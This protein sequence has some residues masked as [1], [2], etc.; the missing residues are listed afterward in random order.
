MAEINFTNLL[1]KC[2]QAIRDG[3]S[4]QA[5]SYLKFISTQ[6]TP[7]EII[8]KFSELAYRANQFLLAIKFLNPV[9]HPKNLGVKPASPEEKLIYATS[10][11]HLGAIEEATVR[12]K[13]L[14]ADANPEILLHQAFA[15]FA[16]WKYT[17]AIPVLRRYVKAKQL[18]EYRR[19]VGQLNLA[20][21]FVFSG[22]F[23]KAE[24]LL[25][26]IR[27]EFKEQGHS[28]LLGNSLELSA[29]LCLLQNNFKAAANYISEAEII[30]T[31]VSGRYLFYVK[32]TQVFIQLL[33]NKADVNSLAKL[34]VLRNEARD[35]KQ[36]ETLRDCDLFEA[37]ATHNK[38]LIVKLLWGTPHEKYKQRVLSLTGDTIEKLPEFYWTISGNG[39]PSQEKLDFSQLLLDRPKLKLLL[40]ALTQDFYKPLRIGDLFSRIYSEEKF[41]A[42]SSPRR[43]FSCVHQL[44]AWFQQSQ[45]DLKVKIVSGEFYLTSKN[46]IQLRFDVLPKVQSQ[47][48]LE[49][50]VLHNTVGSK[51][52]TSNQA[53]EV[54]NMS[55]PA[56]LKILRKALKSK[57]MLKVGDGKSTVYR[58]SKVGNAA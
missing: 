24:K 42:L 25:V 10:L 57:S 36:W 14:D 27:S 54:L 51:T 2:D 17:S 28:L 44:N 40:N 29:H 41:D 6:N 22:Q 58:F 31:K 23:V 19:C 43:L 12:L 35:L 56:T 52:F 47:F 30:L 26:Q 18:P 1:E 3:H 55:K 16:E 50:K 5:L 21:A 34:N 20:A 11:L 53:A 49:L 46:G 13:E 9:I 4:D 48:R 15:Y 32:K 39:E 8:F 37:I 38:E 33:E 45:I 7:R